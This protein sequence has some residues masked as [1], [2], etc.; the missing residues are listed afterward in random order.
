MAVRPRSISLV[1]LRDRLLAAATNDQ[2]RLTCAAMLEGFS[3]GPDGCARVMA[4]EFA[5]LLK[6]RA[7][8]EAMYAGL[9]DRDRGVLPPS[10]PVSARPRACPAFPPPPLPGAAVTVCTACSH[11]A[12]GPGTA[13]SRSQDLAADPSFAA[14]LPELGKAV[15][16]R[17]GRVLAS[18]MAKGKAMGEEMDRATQLALWPAMLREA[19]AHELRANVARTVQQSV[20]VRRLARARVARPDGEGHDW[21]QLS[22]AALAV[23]ACAPEAAAFAFIDDFMGDQPD[24]SADAPGPSAAQASVSTGAQDAASGS[25]SDGGPSWLSAVARDADRALRTASPDA[26]GLDAVLPGPEELDA[27]A[28]A[29]AELLRRLRGVPHEVNHELAAGA[30]PGRP[31]LELQPGCV[32]VV[33]WGGDAAAWKSVAVPSELGAGPLLGTPVCALVWACRDIRVRWGT[34]EGESAEL[35]AG[36]LGVVRVPAGD[37]ALGLRGEAGGAALAVV[38]LVISQPSRGDLP[39]FVRSAAEAA[40]SGPGGGK[41]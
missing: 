17:A 33:S 36:C 13:W 11:S 41:P 26:C 12:G 9:D 39:A 29:A 32:G 5:A 1:D 8:R 14:M 3:L 37:Q 4:G 38:A 28:P 15:A 30:V 2:A 40:A 6:P 10:L 7:F 21:E 16:A 23:A 31:A 19:L 20:A 18:V 24:G 27:S 22:E 35:A 25:G 34:A